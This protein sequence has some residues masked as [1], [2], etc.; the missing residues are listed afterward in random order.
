[1]S[2][3]QIAEKGHNGWSDF[4]PTLS[5]MFRIQEIEEELTFARTSN[6]M[7]I[8]LI[9]H[10]GKE[11]FALGHDGWFSATEANKDPDLG[12]NS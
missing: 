7:P 3:L 5:R 4:S 10:Y 12:Q 8:Q 6:F 2:R 11:V 1:M 9:V